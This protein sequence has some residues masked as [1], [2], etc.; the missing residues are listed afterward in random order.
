MDRGVALRR[1]PSTGSRRLQ[2]IW[3]MKAPSG[4]MY[5]GHQLLTKDHEANGAG[6]A[7]GLDGEKIAGVQGFPWLLRNWR[8]V[9]LRER[10]GAGSMR[11]FARMLATV[12]RPTST[13]RP[14]RAS[15]ILV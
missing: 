14:R 9:R 8:Q 1:K 5:R 12:V 13:L 7:E 3:A 10:S 4:S 15:R 2:A 11:A 6:R